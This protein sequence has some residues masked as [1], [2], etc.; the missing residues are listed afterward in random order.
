MKGGE[1]G[2]DAVTI[3]SRAPIIEARYKL[4]DKLLLESNVQQVIELAAGVLPRG[5]LLSKQG[6]VYVETEL[7][8][9]LKIKKEV[10]KKLGVGIPKSLHF[11]QVNALS[12]KELNSATK[13]LIKGKPVAIIHEGLLR[14][15]SFE[16]KAIVANNIHSVLS[17]YGGVWITCDITLIE[18]MKKELSSTGIEQVKKVTGV[19]IEK[20]AFESVKEAKTFFEKL[21]FDVEVHYLKEMI[22]DLHSPKDLN[23]SKEETIKILG[24]WV[25]FRMKLKKS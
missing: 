1:E 23:L 3:V 10:L 19:N 24:E 4:I 25:T 8:K 13:Y 5:L 11:V 22:G 2:F 17:K 12:S 7:P 9:V 20:N 18:G 16:Q 21:G 14:Y 15:L 6:F